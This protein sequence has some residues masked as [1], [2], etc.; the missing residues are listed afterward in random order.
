MFMF[1]PK[2]SK[3]IYL[4]YCLIINANFF[5][6]ILSNGRFETTLIFRAPYQKTNWD[7]PMRRTFLILGLRTETCYSD[8][9]S[10]N[11]HVIPLRKKNVSFIFCSF[12][13]KNIWQ[14]GKS[15][16]DITFNKINLS[17]LLVWV[18][19]SCKL[20]PW[21]T[22]FVIVQGGNSRV[23]KGCNCQ[24]ILCWVIFL[25]FWLCQKKY[26]CQLFLWA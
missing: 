1:N 23:S 3:S 4:S 26:K 10:V 24:V 15:T 20:Y 7:L 2:Y 9:Y 18:K 22:G 25:L 17:I 14:N 6:L 8:Q 13:T 5:T 12:G 16:P 11:F 21:I 19:K